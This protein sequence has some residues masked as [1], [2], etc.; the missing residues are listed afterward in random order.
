ML[1]RLSLS[2]HFARKMS[3]STG[4]PTLKPFSIAFIQLGGLGSNKTENIKHAREM[5]L[6]AA[7]GSGSTRPDVVVLPVNLPIFS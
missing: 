2:R 1:S 5:V 7:A 3:T 6:K 4:V